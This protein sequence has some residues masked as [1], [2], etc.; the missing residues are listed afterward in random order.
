MEN[1][2]PHKPKRAPPMS[3]QPLYNCPQCAVTC[4]RVVGQAL[5]SSAWA[6]ALK[7]ERLTLNVTLFLMRIQNKY[8]IIQATKNQTKL[9]ANSC[10]LQLIQSHMLKHFDR[11]KKKKKK[12][13]KFIIVTFYISWHIRWKN[14]KW[15]KSITMLLRF[16][17]SDWLLFSVLIHSLPL[18]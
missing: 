10:C 6:V 1:I 12:K 3:R 16:R 13:W 11:I 18:R 2:C 4:Q 9:C 7:A 8:N 5:F 14:R 15:N 17:N